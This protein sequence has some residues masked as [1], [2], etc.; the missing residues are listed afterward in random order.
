MTKTS[1]RKDIALETF[2]QIHYI[3]R[4]QDIHP[5]S[6]CD[7]GWWWKVMDYMMGG[8][9]G[10][11]DAGNACCQLTGNYIGVEEEATSACC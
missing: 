5:L 1:Q 2:A 3:V 4:T 10:S 9:E 8:N 7:N 11:V 6:V